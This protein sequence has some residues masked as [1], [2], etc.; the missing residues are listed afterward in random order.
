VVERRIKGILMQS[1]ASF[2]HLCS[3]ETWARHKVLG[4]PGFGLREK[5]PPRLVVRPFANPHHLFVLF[6]TPAVIE[7][8]GKRVQI[9][10]NTMMVWAP[11][12]THYLGN[13][14]QDWD[15]SWI[16][17]NGALV[18]ESLREDGI[19][20]NR[21]FAVGAVDFMD[22]FLRATYLEIVNHRP[23]DPVILQAHFRA[24]VR[25]LAR[26]MTEKVTP[27]PPKRLLAI[28]ELLESRYT[29]PLRLEKL[30][31]NA[32][33]SVSHFCALYKHYFG[34]PPIEYLLRIRMQHASF[35]L[36]DLQL[37]VKEVAAAV[38]Y[39][40]LYYFSKLFKKRHGASPRQYRA[41][42]KTGVVALSSAPVP[43]PAVFLGRAQNFRQ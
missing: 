13:E 1:S 38:G 22:R 12:E 5:M 25:E 40:D 4:I 31:R 21:P 24:F 20:C 43:S 30:A 29:E 6:H 18:A 35:L 37:S 17:M 36:H 7:A 42:L 19:P 32:H 8:G 23:P 27:R 2:V 28:K 15:H 16:H 26:A 3:T 11:N 39:E 34:V 9:P 10:H 14:A 33:L 41:R